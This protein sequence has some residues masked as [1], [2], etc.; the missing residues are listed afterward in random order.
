MKVKINEQNE[1]KEQVTYPC[2]M[3][4]DAG[5]VIIALGVSHRGIRGVVLKDQEPLKKDIGYYS[6]TYNVLSF[7]P[8]KGTITLSND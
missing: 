7:K 6:E 3:E 4:S 5:T 1:K 2:L 8:F